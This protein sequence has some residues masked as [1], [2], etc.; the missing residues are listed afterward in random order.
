MLSPPFI[1]IQIMLDNRRCVI[2]DRQLDRGRLEIHPQTQ[3]AERT[4]REYRSRSRAI[5]R[6]SV[7]ANG[8][9]IESKEVVQFFI[10]SLCERAGE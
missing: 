8:F 5:N 6:L 7:L 9:G 3:L 4:L 2:R 10:R 1:T